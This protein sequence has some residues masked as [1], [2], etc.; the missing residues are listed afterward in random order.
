MGDPDFTQSPV[1]NT[2]ADIKLLAQWLNKNNISAH[3]VIQALS[4]T[5]DMISVQQDQF[6]AT[7]QSQSMT[8]LS[9][10]QVVV[11]V[12]FVTSLTFDI[13]AL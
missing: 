11:A 10:S 9:Q 2:E 1:V 4:T 5:K 3:A 6:I 8:N 12:N 13:A 7:T